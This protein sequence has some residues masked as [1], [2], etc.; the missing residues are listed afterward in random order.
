MI[1]ND[2]VPAAYGGLLLGM[3]G[4]PVSA[5]QARLLQSGFPPGVADG[6][7]GPATEAAV[8]GFQRSNGLLADGVVGPR[9][10]A[11]LQLAG[12]PPDAMP[13]VTTG[14]ASR[15]FPNT[16]VAPIARNLPL[17][18]SSLQALSLTSA[19]VVLAALATIRAE[20]EGFEPIDEG[21][22]RFN[23]SP[24]GAEF[25]LYD[26]RRDLGN[27]G[28]PD[29][30]AFKGRGFVQLTGRANYRRFAIKL[31][32]PELVASPEQANAPDIAARLLAQF[33]LD[34][35]MP[36]KRAL[37]EGRLATAR[38]LINGGTNGLGRFADA[39]QTGARLLGLPARRTDIAA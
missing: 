21:V 18:L 30:A 20:T 39:Y 29:G 26:Y 37:L 12:Q 2:S 8:L 15:M 24:G 13:P 1:Q 10:A 16:P 7:F 25:D 6:I 33:I 31:G 9:T 19:P 38:E 32:L 36:L 34:V 14:I 35:E 17:V 4:K 23:T 5:L 27:Q 22:S 11:A 3:S 28:P